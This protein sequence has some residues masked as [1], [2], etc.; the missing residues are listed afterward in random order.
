MWQRKARGGYKYDVNTI[1]GEREMIRASGIRSKTMNSIWMVRLR[2]S[3]HLEKSRFV[4]RT[5]P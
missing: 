2:I 1:R 5:K 4:E 3:Y